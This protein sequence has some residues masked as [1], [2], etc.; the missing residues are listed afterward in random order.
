VQEGHALV[1]LS[2]SE[3][4]LDR[5]V[6]FWHQIRTL[7]TG[8]LAGL[9]PWFFSPPVLL[10]AGTGASFSDIR[11][12]HAKQVEKILASNARVRAQWREA[13][14]KTVLAGE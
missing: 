12:L 1:D 9:L 8:T 10:A 13:Q 2:D 7:I 5:H 14:A 6:A 4:P 3:S 11:R